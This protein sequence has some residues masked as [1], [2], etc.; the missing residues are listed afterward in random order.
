MF[1]RVNGA[2]VYARGANKVPMEL[3]EGRMTAYAH[4]RLVQSAALG[5]FNMLRVWGGGVW[6]PRAFYDA[7]DEHGILIYH[8]AQFTFGEVG[9]EPTVHGNQ[10]RDELTYQINRLSHH[11]SVVHYAGCNECIYSDR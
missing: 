11:P 9:F 6:E 8:D 5:R 1:F 2:V 10:L 7:A 4:Q 3:M